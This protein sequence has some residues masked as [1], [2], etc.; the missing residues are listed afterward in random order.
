MNARITVIATAVLGLALSACSSMGPE[1]CAATDWAAVGYEDGSRGLP[2]D[3]FAGHRKAC[4]KHGITADFTDYKAG[5]D[6]GLAE[7]CQPSRAYNLGV[8]GGRYHGVCDVAL[9]EEFL[10]AYQVGYQLYSL[11][12]NVYDANTQISAREN[13]LLNIHAA[14]RDK[15]ARLISV[16][17]T[18]QERVLL[19]ADLQELSARTGELEA[20]IDALIHVRAQ[21]EAALAEYETSVAAYDY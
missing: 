10:D 17:P 18:P 7:F 1:E 15:Q 19:L 14:I 21:H 6:E 20:E 9:E 2:T 12:A 3:H 11:R 16:E 13:A 5:R 8:S 4:A